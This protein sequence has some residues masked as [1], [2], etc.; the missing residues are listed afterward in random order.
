MLVKSA[1]VGLGSLVEEATSPPPTTPATV[2]DVDAP[3]D[4][5]GLVLDVGVVDAGAVV[6]MADDDVAV[7]VVL[8][9]AATVVE[10]VVVDDVAGVD[11]E[12]L[13]VDADVVDVGTSV[14]VGHVVDVVVV[15]HAWAGPANT[16]DKPMA[17]GTATRIM[18]IFKRCLSVVV[19]ARPSHPLGDGS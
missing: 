5:G 4:D 10:G 7:A 12:V 6:V 17:A 15:S 8:E 2:E 1:T 19:R 3:V 9:D 14:V 13:V 11:V 18:R 16:A